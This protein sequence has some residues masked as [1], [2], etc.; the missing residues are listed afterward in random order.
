MIDTPQHAQTSAQTL[1]LIRLKVP[2]SQI[3]EV[4]GPA[5]HELIATLEAQGIAPTGPFISHHFRMVPG[6]FDFELGIPVAQPVQAQG[7]VE[8]GELVARAVVR[9]TYRGGYEGLGPAWG[10]F[11][12]WLES[13]GLQTAEDLWESYDKGPESSPNPADWCTS[14]VQPLV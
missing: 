12:A 13:E 1:A 2:Q 7:R 10:Q 6:I 14:L 11:K 4:M 8:P 9:T 3:Q 5:F